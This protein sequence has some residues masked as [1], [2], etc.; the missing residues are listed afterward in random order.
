MRLNFTEPLPPALPGAGSIATVSAHPTKVG[1]LA[2]QGVTGGLRSARPRTNQFTVQIQPGTGVY[3]TSASAAQGSLM[4][5]A[6]AP[7]GAKVSGVPP[8]GRP[9]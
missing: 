5:D 4:T 1:L 9:V 2:V 8:R 7:A 3:G 6:V